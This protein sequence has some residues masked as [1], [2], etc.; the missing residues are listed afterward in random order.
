[1]FEGKVVKGF[2]RGGKHLDCP[3]ANL[4]MQV[5][6]ALNSGVWAGYASLSG[7]TYKSVAN[8]GISPFY[9]SDEKG[10]QR[11]IEV[12]LLD[13]DGED[14]YGATLNVALKIWMRAERADFASETELRECIQADIQKARSLL[15][16]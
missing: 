6:E 16:V 12:H 1:V 9:T 5:P 3:T 7:V 8:V 15:P 14:F 13:Y 10:V 2:G 11:I 4:D